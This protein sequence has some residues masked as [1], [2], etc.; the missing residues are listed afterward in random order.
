MEKANFKIFALFEFSTAYQHHILGC[1]R[2]FAIWSGNVLEFSSILP[3][4]SITSPPGSKPATPIYPSFKE[5]N[6]FKRSKSSLPSPSLAQE[7]SPSFHAQTPPNNQIPNPSPILPP[8]FTAPT[9]NPISPSPIPL[10]HHLLPNQSRR[11]LAHSR[12]PSLP[13]HPITLPLPQK[14]N[15]N[16]NPIHPEPS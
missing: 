14:K 4:N 10:L 11:R 5:A 16:T 1:K 2:N 13:S 12:L 8:L 6:A 7:P 3:M 9:T 15:Q